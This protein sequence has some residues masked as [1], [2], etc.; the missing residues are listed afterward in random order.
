[1]SKRR[2]K[3]ET[4][5]FSAPIPL[6]HVSILHRSQFTPCRSTM[7]QSHIQVWGSA[8]GVGW[9]HQGNRCRK[10]KV[11][12]CA[13][14]CVRHGGVVQHIDPRNDRYGPLGEL[15]NPG[16]RL[17]WQGTGVMPWRIAQA[18]RQTYSSCCYTA[19]VKE[20]LFESRNKGSCHPRDCEETLGQGLT[21]LS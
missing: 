21:A 11:W 15:W 20:G 13:R 17:Q 8:R 10:F 7:Y 2:I 14:E 6:H 19:R 5:S 9:F 18:Q 3:P 4:V 1:M 16:G 12:P